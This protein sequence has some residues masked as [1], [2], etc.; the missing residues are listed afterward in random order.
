MNWKSEARDVKKQTKL[1][2]KLQWKWLRKQEQE[3]KDSITKRDNERGKETFPSPP[4]YHAVLE[5]AS[6]SNRHFA[7]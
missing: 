5:S 1:Q 2:I 6:A 7:Y 4:P 3:N